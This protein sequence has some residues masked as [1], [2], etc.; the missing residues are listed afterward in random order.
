MRLRFVQKGNL[1]GIIPPALIPAA[2]SYFTSQGVSAS[3]VSD[4]GDIDP[5]AIIGLVYD[6]V[7]FRSRLFPAGSVTYNLKN[8]DRSPQATAMLKLVQPAVILKSRSQGDR[9]LFAPAG[10]PSDVAPEIS[11]AA[12]NIGIGVG[13]VALGLVLGGVALARWKR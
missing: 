2:R 8:T 13:A 5:Q 9:V 6:E 3:A 4:S 1:G 7:E 10:V 12:T 11:S